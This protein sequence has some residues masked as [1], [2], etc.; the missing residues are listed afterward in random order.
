MSSKFEVSL[1]GSYTESPRYI[2]SNVVVVMTSLSAFSALF[3][4]IVEAMEWLC[5][6]K[7]RV[8]SRWLCP[9]NFSD[10]LHF[11]QSCQFCNCISR[12]MWCPTHIDVGAVHS[13]L[14]SPIMFPI[15]LSQRMWYDC[16]R[17]AV[18]SV[19]GCVE[20]IL[21]PS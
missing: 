21:M 2:Q 8:C 9:S 17:E 4:V 5:K 3:S 12:S 14:V 6:V 20:W 1:K 7:R 13:F 10:I 15:Q 19:G 11:L 18:D 16:C